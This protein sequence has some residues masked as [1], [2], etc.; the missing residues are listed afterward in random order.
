M[1]TIQGNTNSL[2][3]W[4]LKVSLAVY[5]HILWAYLLT[6]QF[7]F[8]KAISQKY[9][10]ISKKLNGYVC[11][12]VCC[13]IVGKTTTLEDNLKCSLMGKQV[14]LVCHKYK[15]LTVLIMTVLD[16]IGQRVKLLLRKS[17]TNYYILMEEA[18][19]MHLKW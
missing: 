1:L 13:S 2:T 10:H 8:L 9:S 6:Q 15:I 19:Y 3:N 18:K 17:K 12:Y 7:W 4:V 14:Y 16:W 11:I 5:I